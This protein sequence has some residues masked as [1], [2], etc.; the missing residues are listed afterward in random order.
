MGILLEFTVNASITISEHYLLLEGILV[1]RFPTVIDL[2]GL[3]RVEDMSKVDQVVMY[4]ALMMCGHIRHDT[5]LVAEF[6]GHRHSTRYDLEGTPQALP[7]SAE[8]C[9]SM[10]I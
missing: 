1:Q 3:E 8:F 4:L 9:G 10:G 5:A 2:I 7:I 6:R